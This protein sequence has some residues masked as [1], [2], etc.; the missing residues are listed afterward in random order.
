MHIVKHIGRMLISFIKQGN[1][2]YTLQKLLD[3]K[4]EKADLSATRGER[5]SIMYTLHNFEIKKRLVEE[6]ESKIF[7][8]W[9]NLVPS[10]T[11]KEFIANLQW[12][13]S[14]KRENGDGT[15]RLTREIGLTS[16]GIVHLTRQNDWLTSFY[17]EDTKE[18]WS[19]DFFRVKADEKAIN[20]GYADKDG[21]ITQNAKISL[22][23][24]DRV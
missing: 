22:C 2:I 9:K 13:C 10:L 7:S 16:Q 24:E 12:L 15:G 11:E 19:G 23:A 6:G 21:M 17:R 20:L 1:G 8:A 14:D 18:L 4:G 3:F 5:K